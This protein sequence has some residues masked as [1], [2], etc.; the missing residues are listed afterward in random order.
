MT[1][2]LWYYVDAQQQ[3]I[4]PVAAGIIKDAYQRGELRADSLVWNADLP[5]WQSLADHSEKLG[6]NLSRQTSTLPNGRE[7]KYANFFHRWAAFVF[8]QCLLSFSALLL[9]F[10]VTAAIYFL[11]GFS[12]EKNPDAAAMLMAGSVFIYM[13]LYL[14]MSGSY[15]IHF[16]SSSRQGSWGKQYL[17]LLVTT[18]QGECLDKRT[19]ALRWFSAALSHLSQNIGFLMAAFTQKRQALHDFLANTLVIERDNTPM[20]ANID[21]NKR[22][23]IVLV[24]G[25]VVLPL[26]MTAAIMV[27][28]FYFI[29]QQEQAKLADHEKIAALV[30]PIQQ[31]IGKRMALDQN[32]LSNDD[33]EIKPLL[34]PLKPITTEIYV[35]ISENEET[36]EIYITWDTYKTLAYNYSGEGDWTCEAS[37]TPDHFGGNCQLIDY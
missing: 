30:L 20:A 27:P 25:I 28:M 10:S 3:K 23:I 33:A 5:Q 2:K 21:R 24:M 29:E 11:A 22:C 36:C 32:C 8:D 26:L 13:L 4:G 16:E 19:A 18:D 14:A 9:V 7:V 15:H 12:F 35:G 17:G 31:A 37:H 1:E 34:E 6:I